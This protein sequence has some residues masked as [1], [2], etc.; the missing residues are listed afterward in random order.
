MFG[1][2]DYFIKYAGFSRR[3][4][5]P[6]HSPAGNLETCSDLICVWAYGCY[7]FLSMICDVMWYL[8]QAVCL[9][10]GWIVVNVGWD[11]RAAVNIYHTCH[12][13]RALSLLECDSRKGRP[14][15]ITTGFQSRRGKQCAGVKLCNCLELSIENRWILQMFPPGNAAVILFIWCQTCSC[16][17]FSTNQYWNSIRPVKSRKKKRVLQTPRVASILSPFA[18]MGSCATKLISAKSL[19]NQRLLFLQEHMAIWLSECRQK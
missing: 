14:N 2:R 10:I 9:I 7:S 19:W 17:L 13:T 18:W 8:S 15:K 4:L 1:L 12:V 16:R 3:P 5:Y 11:D 6:G